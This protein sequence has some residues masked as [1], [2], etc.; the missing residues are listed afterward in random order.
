MR[1]VSRRRLGRSLRGMRGVDWLLGVFGLVRIYEWSWEDAPME[2]YW[3][4]GYRNFW[5]ELDRV[6][7][8]IGLCRRSWY[9][10]ER[11]AYERVCAENRRLGGEGV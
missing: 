3:S 11:R 10:D 2:S 8:W 7:S 6:L 5:R 9:V 1:L 4:W